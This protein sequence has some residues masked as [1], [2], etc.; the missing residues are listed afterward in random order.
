MNQEDK[1]QV[2]KI[3]EEFLEKMTITDFSISVDWSSPKNQGEEPVEK[4]SDGTI[5]L[6]IEL[7]EP[8]FLIG[9]N[10]QTL[11]E[12]QKVL[13][14]M[15]NKKLQKRFYVVLD[16]NNYKKQKAE[17]LK[18]LA[19]DL[20]NEVALTKEKKSLPPMPNHE[21]RIIHEELSGRNDV[22]TESEGNGVDRYIVIVPR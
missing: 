16:I 10:G 4:E 9:Q 20:A 22:A 17:Y 19:K 5:T 8:Q 3:V 14:V 12:L 1:E 15:L 18:N 2:K 21:R 11:F 6:N 7:K 13:R